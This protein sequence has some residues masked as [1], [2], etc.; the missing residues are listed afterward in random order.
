LQFWVLSTDIM[1]RD[2]LTH[3]TKKLK[4]NLRSKHKK[5]KHVLRDNPVPV[6]VESMSIKDYFG[7]VNLPITTKYL[8]EL[9]EFQNSAHMFKWPVDEHNDIQFNFDQ[10][11][12]SVD[13]I[14]GKF[15]MRPLTKQTDR[16]VQEPNF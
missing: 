10:P 8:N 7:G 5:N 9:S 12:E 4:Q 1:G 15:L 13:Q 3:F 2:K 11:R 14:K 16:H 6:P